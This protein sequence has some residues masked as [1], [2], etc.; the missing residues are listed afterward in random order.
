VSLLEVARSVRNLSHSLLGLLLHS[1]LFSPVLGLER[2][3]GCEL[4]METRMEH[5]VVVKNLGRGL[6]YSL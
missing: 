6:A 4:E 1:W 3:I 2:K 5:G